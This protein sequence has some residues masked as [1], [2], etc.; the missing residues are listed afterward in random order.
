MLAAVG[1]VA[2][3]LSGLLGVG[4]GIFIVPMLV[5]VARLSQHAAHAT[6][7]GALVPIAIAG[8]LFFGARSHVDVGIA[9]LL[10][11]GTL[12]GA[13]LGARIM[14]GLQEATLKIGFGSLL[15]VVGI[16]MALR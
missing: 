16:L 14:A 8:S 6:S 4:G 13:P 15:V 7:L 9:L 11:A 3:A 2:G 12:V 5:L 1:I 10:A